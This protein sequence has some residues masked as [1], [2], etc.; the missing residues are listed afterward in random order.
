MG[1]KNTSIFHSKALQKYQNW[2]FWFE[3]IPSGNHDATA[4]GSLPAIQ[5]C[6]RKK[7]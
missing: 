7:L 5:S 2:D 4:L 1:I 6:W 3:K